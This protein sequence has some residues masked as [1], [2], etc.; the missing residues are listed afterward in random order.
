MDF[1]GVASFGAEGVIS[2]GEGEEPL[3]V[4]ESMDCKT[5]RCTKT[6]TW[7]GP[8]RRATG[9][10]GREFSF[11]PHTASATGEDGKSVTTAALT[12]ENDHTNWYEVE[13]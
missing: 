13:T 11:S 7:R 12:C 8:E 9:T 5:A 2:M 4:N 6:V 1:L 3:H 10:G